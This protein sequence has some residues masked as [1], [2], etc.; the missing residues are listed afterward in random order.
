MTIE[1][2]FTGHQFASITRAMEAALKR[3]RDIEPRALRQALFE[4]VCDYEFDV[5]DAALRRLRMERQFWPTPSEAI[6]YI[7][8]E[9]ARQRR[10]VAV[11]PA[12]EPLVH[13]CTEVSNSDALKLLSALFPYEA[14]HVGCKVLGAVCPVCAKVHASKNPFIQE[15]MERFP[16]QTENWKP[17]HKGLLICPG[18]SESEAA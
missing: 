4:A 17:D 12:G 5:V 1:A 10:P 9:L 15:L 16:D 14:K 8:D 3:P 6:A 11:K 2:K 18:C 13:T 7:E